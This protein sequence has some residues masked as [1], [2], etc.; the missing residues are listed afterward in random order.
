MVSSGLVC[1]G[2]G[3]GGGGWGVSRVCIIYSQYQWTCAWLPI[4]FCSFLVGANLAPS[5]RPSQYHSSGAGT[6]WC[7][8]G[9][10]VVAKSGSPSVVLF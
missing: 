1:Q 7:L 5:S 6:E 10:A 4:D 8:W 3:V 2:S 9:G